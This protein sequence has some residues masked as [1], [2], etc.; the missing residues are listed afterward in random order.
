MTRRRRPG[1]GRTRAKA[2][3]GGPLVNKDKTAKERRR[4][5][6]IT[7]TE[8]ETPGESNRSERER[9]GE[10]RKERNRKKYQ[11][12]ETWGEPNGTTAERRDAEK[13]QG[14]PKKKRK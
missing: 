6:V 3:Q 2:T 14:I 1:E 8:A 11:I 7:R 10:Y 13:T 5:N 9:S 4:D 12:R